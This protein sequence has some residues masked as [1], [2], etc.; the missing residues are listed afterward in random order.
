MTKQAERVCAGPGAF[1]A[2][3]PAVAR[4]HDAAL[5][6]LGKAFEDRQPIATLGGEGHLELT[7]VIRRFIAS[8]DDDVAAASIS[9]IRPSVE[10]GLEALARGLGFN[11]SG[12][13]AVDI[14]SILKL[15]LENQRAHGR[16][17]VLAI[18]HA[19]RQP[20]WLIDLVGR[21]VQRE[22][23]EKYGLMIVLSDNPELIA[24]RL[25]GCN[26][27]RLY[28]GSRQGLIQLAPF[29]TAETAT[30]V[31]DWAQAA[32]GGDFA[33]QFD[34]DAIERI[35]EIS[36]GVPDDVAALCCRCLQHANSNR[37][38]CIG[39]ADIDAAAAELDL[40][41]E[42]ESARLALD[43]TLSEE[44]IGLNV[45]RHRLVVRLDGNWINDRL[46]ENGSI[47]IGRTAKADIRLE[48]G[49]VS[50]SHAL[51]CMTE[52]G[53]ELRDL[54]SHNGTYV[55][56]HRIDRHLLAPDDVIRIGNFV[57]E[58]QSIA[59]RADIPIAS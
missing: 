22:A 5:L 56:P 58:Y 53:H 27:S 33:L 50:R 20:D 4:R 32:G 39:I 57:I 41:P 24:D 45:V 6:A 13:S 35:Q 43:D 21:L 11:P 2:A 40:G 26:S 3:F 37:P 19:A 18:G 55:G 25:S 10:K 52:L 8:L 9:K 49:V 15:F 30:F 59:G 16:R 36:R 47:L 48:S 17:T 34:I 54:G 42:D 44:L 23:T 12:L 46:I 1:E 51:V 29:S 7:H 31:R 14:F 28:H 38:G